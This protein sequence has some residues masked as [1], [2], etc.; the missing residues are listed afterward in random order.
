MRKLAVVWLLFCLAAIGAASEKKS[1]VAP[2]GAWLQDGVKW[3]KAPAEINAH[4]QTGQATI[5]F[6]RPDHTFAIIYCVVNRV[7]RRYLTISHGDGQV[8]YLGKW[9][10]TDDQISTTYRLTS[11]TVQVQGE[12]LPGPEQRATIKNSQSILVLDGKSYRRADALN[13]SAAEVVNGT[14]QS[15]AESIDPATGNQPLTIPLDGWGGW[16]IFFLS[17]S[18]THKKTGDRR[19]VF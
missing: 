5:L 1:K 16:P 2:T 6:F 10:V 7:P 17:L 9:E 13:K 14:Q 15:T 19:D 18:L 12:N 3:I 8:V 4:L 11:R